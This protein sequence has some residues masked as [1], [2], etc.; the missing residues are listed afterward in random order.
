MKVINK[1]QMLSIVFES[2]NNK[3]D[4]LII[5]VR[6]PNEV[7]LG[8]IPSS[9]NIPLGT[10]KDLFQFDNTLFNK[11][12]GIDKPLLDRPIIL[13]C[14][15]GRRSLEACKSLEEL[16]YINISNYEGSWL[17]WIEGLDEKVVSFI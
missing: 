14:R 15:S 8:S 12:I 1:D 11:S 5:D 4:T 6:E 2:Q 9:I 3:T 7:A 17:N 13:Y 10:I 16:G